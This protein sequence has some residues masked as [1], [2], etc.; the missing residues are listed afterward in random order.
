MD[1]REE[2]SGNVEN[3]GEEEVKVA[4]DDSVEKAVYDAGT[5]ER[6]Q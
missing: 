5:T 3:S 6:R 2:W 4:L 1:G